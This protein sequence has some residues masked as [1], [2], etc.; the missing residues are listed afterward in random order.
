[1]LL[2]T[3]FGLVLYGCIEEFT[4]ELKSSNHIIVI[5]GTLVKGES[6]QTITVSAATSINNPQFIPVSNCQV[7]V[8]GESENI[9]LF[10]ETVP[11]IY[12]CS[13]QDDLLKYDEDYSLKLTTS[14]QIEFRSDIERLFPG[15]PIDS[16]YFE[17]TGNQTSS[18]ISN[19]GLQLYLDLKAPE[20]ATQNYRWTVEETWE[21]LTF[22]SI[23]GYYDRGTYKYPVYSP[24]SDSIN[25][26][27][28]TKNVN[29]IYTAST[30]NLTVNEKKKIPLNYVPAT[31][32]KLDVKYSA[33][34][35]Q[36]SLSNSAYVHW[37]NKKVSSQESGGL[38][39]DQPAQ[40]ISNIHC[41]SNPEIEVLGFFSLSDFSEKRIFFEGPIII[42]ERECS[43]IECP[44][45]DCDY[46]KFMRLLESMG[47]SRVYLSAKKF[48]V[49]NSDSVAVWN[50]PLNQQCIDCTTNGAFLQKPEFW[51]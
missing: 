21:I 9:F 38:Y 13:I 30:A 35:K 40:S 26:C 6:I 42:N 2:M 14:D 31:D 11:G 8:S 1:M 3:L 22:V 7:I 23:D 10:E 4:P 46:D 43:F 5:D 45:M 41:T 39:Q 34:I 32:H 33:L 15:S 37:N 16:I 24:I 48:D 36:Y 51:K 17:I 25:Q 29:E 20:N 19:T 27:W 50:I 28:Y 18:D 49:S 47:R 44:S 12:T